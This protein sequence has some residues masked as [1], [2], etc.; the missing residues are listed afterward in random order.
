MM[1]KM[2]YLSGLI[3]MLCTQ[4]VVANNQLTPETDISFEEMLKNNVP[5][6]WLPSALLEQD[7]KLDQNLLVAATNITRAGG[8]KAWTIIIYMAADNDLRSFASRNIKQIAAIGSNKNVNVVVHLDIRINNNFKVTR[9]YYIEKNK[10]N[11]VN[12]HDPKTQQMDSGDEQTLISCCE[13]A[14]K[15]Y[16]ADNYAL[17]FWDHGTGCLDPERGRVINPSY[18][19][20]YN[21]DTRLYDLDRSIGFLEAINSDERGIC[22]DDSTGHYLTNQKLDRALN[23]I[24]TNFLGG[25]KIN[26]IG[27]D[28]C[29]MAMLEIANITKKYADF[30]VSSQEVELGTGWDYAQVL[31]PFVTG[32]LTPAAFAN[33]IVSVYQT[34]YNQV[35]NDYTLSAMDLSKVTALEQ[36]VDEVAHILLDCLK[37][38][39]SNSVKNALKASRNKLLCTCFD[40]PTYTDLAHFYE[41]L[42]ANLQ[43]FD[44][45][46]NKE[47]VG[48]LKKKIA[49]GRKLITAC[50]MSSVVGQNLKRAR[51]ISIYFPERAMHSSYL[52][53]DFAQTNHWAG[54]MRQ[55]LI[56]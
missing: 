3:L 35:T 47:L 20:E 8:K 48:A 44:L 13:W 23:Y 12:A 9:R 18:F 32:S 15:D 10:V 39:N 30:M 1:K 19:F 28:A 17:F 36:N 2:F 14:I 33:H 56:G 53:T 43:H 50:V 21:P 24:T 5:C 51:G 7:S 52:K 4:S 34:T 38:Q 54:L 55:Y 49:E 16:P 41:N 37:Y 22:W 46:Q 25:K 11:H 6:Y 40:E 42:E 29:L 26:V 27:F 45:K 31:T